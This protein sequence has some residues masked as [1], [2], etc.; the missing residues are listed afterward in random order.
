MSELEEQHTRICRKC[1]VASTVQGDF[2]PSC[3]TPYARRSRKPSRKAL[4]AI[5]VVALLVIGAGVGLGV[6]KHQDATE[7]ARVAAAAERAAE[8]QARSEQEAADDAAAAQQAADDTEREGRRDMGTA[9]EK[10]ITKHAK[11]LVKDG[12]LEG[13]IKY[14]SCTATGGGSTDDLTALTGTFECLAVNKE[15]DD[16]T[17]SGYSYAGTAE[18]AT[19]SLTWQLGS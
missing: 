17:A 16:G 14:S 9:L 11:G 8:E 5:G 12:L 3:G 10:R 1:S 19:G 4:V 2:C 18:W 13:P 6:K 15:N 7:R